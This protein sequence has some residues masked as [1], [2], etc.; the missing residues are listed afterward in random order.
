[1]S[2]NTFATGVLMALLMLVPAWAQRAN[3]WPSPPSSAETL[4]GGAKARN[5]NLQQM[6]Q[7]AEQHKAVLQ[8]DT[9]RLSQLVTQL[10]LAL[11]KTPAG[12]LSVDAV[13]KVK[14][15]EKLAKRVR[16]EIEED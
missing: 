14:E 1:M 6:Q 5:L 13:K 8:K 4:R 9:E 11:D 16:K 2:T 3:N 15:I 7:L 12:T 10:K